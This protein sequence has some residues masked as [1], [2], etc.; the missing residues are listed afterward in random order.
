MNTNTNEQ[1]TTQFNFG[2]YKIT[3]NVLP[4]YDCDMNEFKTLVRAFQE[5][6]DDVRFSLAEE[7]FLNKTF[8]F[9]VESND[10]IKFETLRK[11]VDFLENTT[12]VED[13][14]EY[15]TAV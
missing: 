4:S 8:A 10:F 3:F 13:T 2:A 9:T 15:I 5:N 7:V 12:V 11:I 1:P 6:F 14:N